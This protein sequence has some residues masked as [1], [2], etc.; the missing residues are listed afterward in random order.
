MKRTVLGFTLRADAMVPLA[1]ICKRVE[2][3]FG[4]KLQEDNYHGIPVLK[5]E[6]LGMRILLSQWCGLEER[7]TF[8]LH[9]F[10]DDPRFLEGSEEDLG[11]YQIDISQAIIDLL[12][13]HGAG[14]WRVPS[15]VEIEAEIEYGEAVR[16][17]FLTSGDQPED[18]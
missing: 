9:G 1:E 10:V 13:V 17:K 8:Q 14:D 7:E 5:T 4:C 15:R 2:G 16:K 11:V 12:A 3:A 18:A 6:L